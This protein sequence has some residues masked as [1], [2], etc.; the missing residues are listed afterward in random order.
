[1]NVMDHT[2]LRDLLEDAEAR[3]ATL[4][5]VVRALV[6]G[7]EV[8]GRFARAFPFKKLVL[9]PH[10]SLAAVGAAAGVAALRRHDAATSD[11]G[12]T[13]RPPITA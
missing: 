1:M 7:Y 4:G 10:A 3:G 8:A 5:E 13:P 2:T 9:H 12:V 11:E 6:I